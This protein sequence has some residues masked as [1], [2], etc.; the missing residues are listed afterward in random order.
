MSNANILRLLGRVTCF[1]H[2][3][4]RVLKQLHLDAT[5]R[6]KCLPKRILIRAGFRFSR[7]QY[8]RLLWRPSSLAAPEGTCKPM[9]QKSLG[10]P[11][12]TGLVLAL[13]ACHL[14]HEAVG[15]HPGRRR[16]PLSGRLAKCLILLRTCAEN[17]GTRWSKAEALSYR[18][19]VFGKSGATALSR[20]F[21]E[22]GGSCFARVSR[23]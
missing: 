9:L 18:E 14:P 16:I 22:G 20:S 6:N 12:Q 1:H 8:P 13:R 4:W 17:H 23:K 15:P 7:M 10:N 19:E 21:K 3:S 11:D 5:A 2:S